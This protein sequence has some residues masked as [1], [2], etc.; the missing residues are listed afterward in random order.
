MSNKGRRKKTRKK[1]RGGGWDP[2]FKAAAK[3][4]DDIRYSKSEAA[5]IAAEAAALTTEIPALSMEEASAK[6]ATAN[7]LMKQPYAST[8]PGAGCMPLAMGGIPESP[9]PLPP[10]PCPKSGIPS[11]LEA[12]GVAG[13]DPLAMIPM[14]PFVGGTIAAEDLREKVVE[15]IKKFEASNKLAAKAKAMGIPIPPNVEGPDWETKTATHEAYR[16]LT[17]DQILLGWGKEDELDKKFAAVGV[18]P[19][20]P[21]PPKPKQG[22]SMSGEEVSE[23][24]IAKLNE[25]TG[26][27]M[28]V[29]EKGFTWKGGGRKSRKKKHR[30]KKRRKTR[31]KR[32]GVYTGPHGHIFTAGGTVKLS[33]E[34]LD[35]ITAGVVGVVARG[36]ERDKFKNLTGIIITAN[37]GNVTIRWTPPAG[38]PPGT[39]PQN[40]IY[41]DGLA[42]AVAAAQQR[43]PTTF[44]I[45]IPQALQP[46]GRKKRR[47]T[48]RKRRRKRRRGAGKTKKKKPFKEWKGRAEYRDNV[49]KLR[50]GRGDDYTNANGD[51]FKK[52]GV[53]KMSDAAIAYYEQSDMPGPAIAQMRNLVGT[54]INANSAGVTIHWGLRKKTASHVI[55]YVDGTQNPTT[56]LKPIKTPEGGGKTR[57]KRRRKRRRRRRRTRRK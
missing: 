2:A 44:L 6:V 20:I 49:D 19:S 41:T 51:V 13:P 5:A 34:A 47:K 16:L 25:G 1:Q 42:P 39:A 24:E 53:V 7:R 18:K 4:A 32:G 43:D 14:P 46:G 30:R 11:W 52:N 37:N 40:I 8:L 27:K 36:H 29:F 38:L 48:R 26:K 22:S 33:D 56:F 9:W 57:R 21:L 12:L 23:A 15:K 17:E 10:L 54:I 3:A 55:I 35:Y 31:R 50:H 28:V 45:P